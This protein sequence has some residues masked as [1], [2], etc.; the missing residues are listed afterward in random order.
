[1]PKPAYRGFRAP[2][3]RRLR[4]DRGWTQER[5]AVEV[6]VFPTMIGKWESGRIVPEVATIARLAAALGVRPQDFTELGPEQATLTDLRL[7]AG[8][9]R[10]QTTARTGISERRLYWFE[11]GTREPADDVA[12][13]LA[14]TYAVTPAVVRRAWERARAAALAS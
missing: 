2:Y 11:H 1:M 5:L 9:S 6:G 8:L 12:A 13:A 14:R 10:A 4:E 7:W 3:L